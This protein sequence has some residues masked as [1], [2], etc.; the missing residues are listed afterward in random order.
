MVISAAASGAFW[1][2]EDYL[3]NSEVYPNISQ[4]K[5][6]IEQNFTI[7]GHTYGLHN[8]SSPIGRYGLG[9][10]A[11]WAKKLGIGEP[12]TIDDVY[13]LSLIHI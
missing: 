10:R 11:D 1:P 7:D 6:E 9:Y 3:Y 5:K 4:A 8:L 2:I 12:S 13:D